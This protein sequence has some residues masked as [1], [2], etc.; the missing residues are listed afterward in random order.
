MVATV[1]TRAAAI[2]EPGPVA[3]ASALRAS[4]PEATALSPAE[5]SMLAE[6]L[7]RLIDRSPAQDASA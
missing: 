7:N 3:A 4:L 5:R 6:W 1:T 2:D